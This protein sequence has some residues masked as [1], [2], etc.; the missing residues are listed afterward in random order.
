MHPRSTRRTVLGT[1]GTIVVG[2]LAGCTGDTETRGVE[3]G[4]TVVSDPDD[5]AISPEDYPIEADDWE[6]RH[7]ENT[8]DGSEY[9]RVE[10]SVTDSAKYVEQNVT[11]YRDERYDAAENTFEEVQDSYGQDAEVRELE[12]GDDAR[13]A[14][15]SEQGSGS[16][17]GPGEVVF[18]ENNVLYTVSGRS[19]SEPK[20]VV[21]DIAERAHG[22]L[23]D[24][25]DSE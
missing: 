19:L 4:K 21:R 12:L 22:N 18:Y 5:I 3:A 11:V 14:Y 6:T 10:A 15:L 20:D 16:E 7:V 2:S 25:A 9:L 17:Q 13:L 23:V 24:A 8:D 1:L